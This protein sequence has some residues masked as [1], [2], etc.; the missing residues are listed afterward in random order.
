MMGTVEVP[1]YFQRDA[2]RT[3]VSEAVCA[4]EPASSASRCVCQVKWHTIHA[5]LMYSSSVMV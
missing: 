2:C 3:C 5:V 4:H 1:L